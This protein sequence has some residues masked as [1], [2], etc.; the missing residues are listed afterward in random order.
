MILNLPSDTPPITPSLTVCHAVAALA[1]VKSN[2]TFGVSFAMTNVPRNSSGNTSILRRTVFMFISPL[3]TGTQIGRS[4]RGSQSD[5]PNH[6]T[7]DFAPLTVPVI[8]LA[9]PPAT[10]MIAGP[11]DPGDGLQQAFHRLD[12]GGRNRPRITWN[13]AT[14]TVMVATGGSPTVSIG[15]FCQ[16]SVACPTALN[17]VQGIRAVFRQ[18]VT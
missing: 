5:R 9:H 15:T 1:P 2:S 7:A 6:A 13:T 3:A 11:Q 8:H 16:N 18:M 14:G 17:S 4:F 12:L 10:S